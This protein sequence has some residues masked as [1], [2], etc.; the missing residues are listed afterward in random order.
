VLLV[1]SAWL[2]AC[3]GGGGGGD[4]GGG[5]GG[6]G[7]GGGGTLSLTADYA[8]LA[9]GDRRQWRTTAGS[10]TG[11]LRSQTV[12]PAVVVNGQPAFEVTDESG[13]RS[14]LARTATGVV[15]IPGER[16]D[17]LTAALGAA[18][19]M[20]F[21]LRAGD[22]VDLLNRTVS[23]D[24][25]GDGRPDTVRVRANFSVLGFSTF[26]LP[27]LGSGSFANTAHVRIDILSN[28]ALTG[29]GGS[30]DIQLEVQEWHAPGVGL[31]RQTTRT[32]VDGGPAAVQT[33]DLVAFGVGGLRSSTDAPRILS[34]SPADGSTAGPNPAISLSFSK[35]LDPLSFGSDG[36]ALLA[37]GGQ[38]VPSRFQVAPDG[39]SA[40]MMP[41]TSLPDGTYTVQVGPAVVDWSN[42]PVAGGSSSFRVDLSAPQV[43]ASVPAR[44]SEGVALTGTVSLTF[45][46]D[47]SAFDGMALFIEIT[48]A[49]GFEVL[50][51]LPATLSG[52]TLSA[53][54]ATPL[55]R[56][57][58]YGMRLGGVVVDT[59][60]NALQGQS[61]LLPFR[62]DPGPLS[63]P[64][65]WAGEGTEVFGVR[66]ADLDGDG[67]ADLVFTGATRPA[68]R[69]F[70][71]LRP[72]LAGGGFG[73]P[74]Q[75]ADLGPICEGYAL[76]VGDFNGDGRA[77]VALAC[78]AFLRVYLRAADGSFVL[79]RPGWNGGEG[80]GVASLNGD[81]R[82]ALV[83]VGTA[84]GV[85]V[86]GMRAWHAIA[87][88]AD[89]S[90]TSVAE[91]EPGGASAA[92]AAAAWADLDNDGLAD[93]V[94]LRGYF[95]G[96]RELAWA[97]QTRS[98]G[99]VLGFGAVQSL[100]L[101][102]WSGFHVSMAVGDLDGD[103]RA[104]VVV[105]AE[106]RTD[107]RMLLRARADGGFDMAA[108]PSTD[109]QV[110]SVA[111]AD[112]DGDGRQDVLLRYY[113]PSVV[114]VHL[115][116]ADGSLQPER[117]F[118]AAFSF[119]V[120]GETMFAVDVDGDGLSDLI[121][122]SAA[123]MGR[124]W[125]GAWP[126]AA[127]QRAATRSLPPRSAAGRLF[128]R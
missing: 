90:W 75:L 83:F 87:R 125:T 64:Q 127:V 12:G 25:D 21:G 66:L 63:R 39:R 118:E 116:S 119:V 20:R 13:A 57:T 86:G 105:A 93:M 113:V 123:L 88:Q 72:G 1:V 17:A 76:V 6:T 95:D 32:Q 14:Y 27:G 124:P 128:G 126:A 18:D 117:L 99:G 120:P 36:I 73:P 59:A 24:L 108:L 42:N 84:P 56:N 53:E 8:P 109:A 23:V 91:V 104:D 51:S 50:Q 38:P 22:S 81:G 49:N 110:M 80:M 96:R 103:G 58:T 19:I 78:Q 85:D 115:Q 114:G 41:L 101:G 2:S 70:L 46:E 122:Q 9:T 98:A 79:E 60:G 67:I 35:A 5:G 61:I 94:W 40:T 112:V 55:Q 37:A 106:M 89:G 45:D 65:S 26:V 92:P 16:A 62:T 68:F 47:V 97:P 52:R 31:L 44:D 74:V 7:G 33:E 77:D 10:E 111:L 15:E 69:P 71:G 107:P 34:T 121:V 11:M 43:V 102:S 48:D 54:L 82:D 28:L 100:P 3:G 4:G 29:G 30:A